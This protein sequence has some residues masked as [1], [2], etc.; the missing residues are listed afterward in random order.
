M[1][2]ALFLSVLAV[3]YLCAT[4]DPRI[5]PSYGRL[6]LNFEINRGQAPAGVIYLSRTRSGTVYLRPASVALEAK[7]GGSITMRFVGARPGARPAGEEKLPGITSYL[8]GEERDW[9]RRVPNYAAVRYAGI[10]PG[11]DA[12]FHGS[13]SDLEYDFMLRPGADPGRI[14]LAFDGAYRV[15][16]DSNGDLELSAS[17]GILK[18]RK[19]KIWQEVPDGRRE[20]A[21]HYV[22]SGAEARFVL[23]AYDRSQALVIDPVINYSTYFGSAHDDMAQ[24][25]TTDAAGAVYITG[26]TATGGISWGFVSKLNPAGTAVVYT[27]YFGNSVC[28]AASRGID[29]D[30]AS[31]ATVT[32]YYTQQDAAGNCTVKQVFGGKIN[33]AGDS[34]IYQL[35]WGGSGG[36]GNAVAVDGAG[37]AYFTGLTKGGFPTTPGVIFPTGGLQGDAFVTKFGPTGT[38]I[39]STYL[40]GSFADEGLAIAVDANGNAYIAGAAGSGNFPTTANAVQ[41]AMPNPTRSGFITEVNATATQILYSTFLGGNTSDEVHGIALTGGKIA[42]TG[43]TTSSNFPTTANA[44]DRTCGSDGTCNAYNNGAW[45]YAEDAFFA[46]IDPLKTGIAALTYSTFVGGGKADFGES[47]AVDNNGRVWITGRTQSAADFPSVQATQGASGGDYDAFVVE[48]DPAQAGAPSL[49]FATFVGGSLYDAG[50]GVTVDPFGNTYVAGY[51]ASTNFPIANA[52]QTQSAGGNDGFLVKIAAPAGAA[53]ALA[54]LKFSPTTIVF[55]G[56]ATGTVTLTA[57]APAGGAVITLTNSNTLQFYAPATVNVPAGATTANFIVSTVLS[58][59]TTT[60]TATYNGINKAV[61]LASVN[62]TVKTLTCTPNPVI[63]EKTTICTVTMNGTMPSATAVWILSDQPFFA[64]AN[65][66]VSVPAGANNTKFSITPTLVPDQIVAHI[67]ADALA[68]ATVTTPL[69][70]NLTNRGK[71]WV[72]NNV[73]FK[74]GATATGYFTYDAAVGKYL[75]VN[76]LVTPGPDPLNPLGHTPQNLYYY[77]WP[78]GFKPTAL[79]NWSTASVLAMQNP[80]GDGSVDPTGHILPL[81]WTYFQFNFAHPLTNN[82][83]TITLVTNPN[84]AYTEHC[85]DNVSPSCTPP[86]G[87]ISQEQFAMPPG[88]G[89]W[90][91]FYYRVVVSGTVTAQ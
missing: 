77:P 27:A 48:I 29:V 23:D 3:P 12:V 11:I 14:R 73:I 35:V 82:A 19:P 55:G 46:K 62:P 1:R 17:H 26:S 85:I 34:F 57:A 24:S 87:N 58:R 67:S 71:K 63:A 86:P 13:Q 44:W 54:G 79:D 6:P 20:V 31:N 89:S 18:Q 66:T 43:L 37:N 49:V 84:V 42:V 9:I 36:Y 2:K 81:S 7:D 47:L 40:G 64:P 72:L 83:G 52:L 80:M 25:V 50:T 39:Y 90:G 65:G 76:I 59:S 75:D 15:A 51:T 78:N 41:A 74:D 22:L 32:G 4:G 30:V 5:I 38:L 69:T 21:G 28:N 70:I 68:T 91:S 8:I 56:T 33:A 60:I 53:P 88:P 16:I 10:Y 61:N 45:H